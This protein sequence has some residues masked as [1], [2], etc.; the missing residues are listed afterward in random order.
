MWITISCT[1][2]RMLVNSLTV[3][4]TIHLRI[5]LFFWGTYYTNFITILITRMR[6]F[7]KH[8]IQI[9]F[10]AIIVSWFLVLIDD[11]FF[12]SFRPLVKFRNI[13]ILSASEFVVFATVWVA[14][15]WKRSLCKKTL[16][17]IIKRY[18]SRAW[19]SFRPDSELFQPEPLGEN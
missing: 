11:F 2:R 6:G 4:K 1:A 18:S 16:T 5:N 12:G 7:V 3:V 8:K 15:L 13:L 19:I 14:I 17:D 10:E 9:K